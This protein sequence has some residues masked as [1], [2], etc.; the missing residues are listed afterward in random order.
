[1]PDPA[2]PDPAKAK[3]DL[4]ARA[5]SD[6]AAKAKAGEPA[7]PDVPD[8]DTPPNPSETVPGGRY[9]RGARLVG[10]KLYGGHVGD[11]HGRV[12]ATFKPTQINTGDPA[13]GKPPG[14]DE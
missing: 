5:K 1:M 7:E 8:D 12:L 4:D 2:H 3:A 11:A 13:D 6:I 9:V 10:S 14:E